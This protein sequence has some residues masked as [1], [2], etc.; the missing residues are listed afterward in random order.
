[1]GD[2]TAGSNPAL[3]VLFNHAVGRAVR[4]LFSDSRLRT[5]PLEFAVG[6]LTKCRIGDVD[7]TPNNPNRLQPTGFRTT[8]RPA[9]NRNRQCVGASKRGGSGLKPLVGSWFAPN[10][11]EIGRASCRERV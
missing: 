10:S 6:F 7:R 9:R 3:S 2:C 5:T 1:M 4:R 11:A 8:I